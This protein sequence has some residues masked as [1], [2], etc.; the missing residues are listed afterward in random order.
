[1]IICFFFNCFY[2]YSECEVQK[3]PIYTFSSG[4]TNSMR[5]AAYL[6]N[7]TDAIIVDIGGTT[8]DVGAIVKG[9]PRESS[10]RVKVCMF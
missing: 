6:A 10:N 8:M 4:A 9:F 1:M 2:F 5:G 3:F 7:L